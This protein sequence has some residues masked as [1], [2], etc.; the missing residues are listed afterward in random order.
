MAHW[1]THK[2]EACHR[3]VGKNGKERPTTLRDARKLGLL[4]SVTGVLDVLAKP[5][6]D[7]W[8]L[9]QFAAAARDNPE[10]LSTNELPVAI[11][12]LSELA[13][14]ETKEAAE[15]G[16]AIHAAVES[17]FR[18]EDF[19]PACASYVEQVEIWAAENGIEF[20]Q[21][22]VVLTN[23]DI[24]YAGTVDALARDSGGRFCVIDFKTKKTRPGVA[25]K[26]YE[27]HMAQI[28]AYFE[29][30]NLKELTFPPMLGANVFLSTTEPGRLDACWYTHSQLVEAYRFFRAAMTVWTYL[31]NYDPTENHEANEVPR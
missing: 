23:P 1:Y 9:T 3:L 19:D 27:T 30:A 4:P 13:S 18:G 2:G 25:V 31:N 29:A 26:P 8:K 12:R 11:A 15:R 10:I 22:E 21:H 24:G 6:L 5:G 20:D 14:A 16:T 28:A 17:Y 7:T